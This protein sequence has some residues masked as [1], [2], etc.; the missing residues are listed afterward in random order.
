[1]KVRGDI[2]PYQTEIKTTLLKKTSTLVSEI[3]QFPVQYNKAIIGK[4]AFRHEAGIHQ[5]GILKERLTY[6]IISPETVGAQ[7][8]LLVLGK[9]SGQ[10]RLKDKLEQLR[11]FKYP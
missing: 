2:Y 4:N 9:H 1:M 5:D 7:E 3:T 6:E 10:S 11:Y 8:S